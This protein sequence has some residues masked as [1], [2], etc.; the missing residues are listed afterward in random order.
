VAEYTVGQASILLV[1]SAKGFM[2]KVSAMA[3]QWGDSA[4]STFSDAFSARVDEG[5]RD[6]IGS[7]DADAAEKGDS[8]GGKFSDSFRFRVDAA[9]KSLPDVKIDGDSSDVD[10]KLAEVRLELVDLS[11][12]TVGVDLSDDEALAKIAILKAALVDIGRS[13]ES[14]SVKVDTGG[15]LGQLG[16]IGAGGGGIAALGEDASGAA[17]S[18]GDVLVPA[19]AALALALIPIGGLLA[20]SLAALPAILGGAGLGISALVLGFSGIPGA[21]SAYNATLNTAGETAT[22]VKTKQDALVN[23]LAGLTPAGRSFVGFVGSEMLPMFQNLKTAVQGAL[24]P[25][26]TAGLQALEPFFRALQPLIVGAASGI[27]GTFSELGKLIGQG[28]G[29]K[30]IT[31]ILHDGNDFM[32]K[33]GGAFVTGFGAL[34]TIGAQA[35]PIV[36]ALGDGIVNMVNAFAKWVSGGGFEKFVTWLKD[37]GPGIVGTI[38]NVARGLGQIIVAA[39]PLGLMLLKI[40]GWLADVIRALAPFSALFVSIF[41][42]GLPQVINFFRDHWFKIWTDIH[43][44]ATTV[45]HALDNDVFQPLVNFFTVTLPADLD[46][47]VGFFQKLPGRIVTAVG[48]LV[49][50]AF[51]T[52]VGIGT[53]ITTNVIDPVVGAFDGIGDAIAK[54][55]GAGISALGSIGT[56]IINGIISG[57]NDGINIVDAHIPSVFGVHLFP[58]IDDIPLIGKASG[59][60]VLAGVDYLVGERGPEILRMG[61]PG[62]VIPHGQNLAPS[63]L[64]GSS[65]RMGPVMHSDQ[66]IINSPV[67]AV[68]LG[69]QLAFLARADRF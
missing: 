5:T 42:L 19:I 30:D 51:G 66:T 24:L 7:Q 35:H 23:S 14:V 16:G 61:S 47:V 46:S 69:Q 36:K 41:T 6:A 4:G 65:A 44:I 26:V 12:K 34:L 3:E 39:A 32:N 38:S 20:G 29:L 49:S 13:S 56:T 37:N 54:A 48:N 28:Q 17:F 9:I 52:L 60:P 68:A 10:R 67:D 50:A 43:D 33:L 22:Q 31:Q 59:G 21:I 1:P 58:H 55:V 45:W 63:G 25:G 62:Y 40:V 27:G 15:A 2:E 64:G 11:R 53:W 18:I 57:I 8:A